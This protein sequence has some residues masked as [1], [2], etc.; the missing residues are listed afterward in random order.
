MRIGYGGGFEGC[1]GEA[2]RLGGPAP[3]AGVG[4]E[5]RSALRVMD[6][7]DFEERVRR[8]LAAEQLLG[9]EGEVGD[10]VNDGLGDASSGVADDGSVSELESEDDRGVDPVVEAGD[11]EHLTGGYAEC[12]R[13]VGTGELLVALEQGGHPGHGG[14]LL[15]QVLPAGGGRGAH[16][17]AFGDV[18]DGCGAEVRVLAGGQV[19]AGK[20]QDLG[21]G[22]ALAGGLDLPV[23][24]GV[25]IAAADVKGDRAAEVAG[26]RREVPASRVATVLGGEPRGAVEEGRPVP[27]G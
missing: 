13:R 6:D 1:L 14:F 23:L 9:Q 5:A 24:V 11:D 18:A 2:G 27:G 8:A 19:A 20:G 12:R 17:V 10:V 25:V 16:A 21:L 4:E 26:D 7:R 15:V 3:E 22:H